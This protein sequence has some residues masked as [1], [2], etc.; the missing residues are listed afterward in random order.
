MKT[1]KFPML[2][3]LLVITGLTA[4]KSTK[5]PDDVVFDENAQSTLPIPS[6]TRTA[7]GDWPEGRKLDPYDTSRVRQP[8]GVH[9]YH[10]G[11]LP[12]H[13][14][15]EMHEAHSVYRIEQSARWDQRLPATPMESRG[16]VFGIREPSHSPIPQD[17][18]VSNERSRQLD[19]S[20][21]IEGQ[22][23]DISQK[24]QKLDAFLA[25]A[26]DKTKTITEL[27]QAK[28]KLEQDL[29]AS[30]SEIVD[31][32]RELQELKDLQAIQDATT[33]KR[34]TATKKP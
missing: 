7:L 4:C 16:V 14:R 1:T 29:T 33:K 18:I 20:A 21:K 30:Q 26:P 19:L 32:K 24:Q 13:D 3:L 25:S 9:T 8:E 10:V 22:L 2:L 5:K 12:S 11:R 15:R 31:L 17:Q 6:F 28:Q 34:D 27:Q 23:A